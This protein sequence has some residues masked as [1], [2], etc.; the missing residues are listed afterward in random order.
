[1]NFSVSSFAFS[2]DDKNLSYG[3][4]SHYCVPHNSKQPDRSEFTVNC[5]VNNVQKHQRTAARSGSKPGAVRSGK[6]EVTQ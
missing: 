6:K 4:D 1:M 3:N 5:P 2:S